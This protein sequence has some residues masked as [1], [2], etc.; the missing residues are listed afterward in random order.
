[1]LVLHTAYINTHM[2][3]NA[4]NLLHICNK[5]FFFLK[6]RKENSILLR[7]EGD[8]DTADYIRFEGK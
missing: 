1:M 8:L 4:Y 3:I 7:K 5:C 6:I 2:V